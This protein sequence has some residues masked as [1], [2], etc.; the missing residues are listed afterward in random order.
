MEPTPKCPVHNQ[1]MEIEDVDRAYGQATW[2]CPQF[3]RGCR[4]VAYTGPS[5]ADI[6]R[7]EYAG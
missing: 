6:L 5:D 4:E 7:R 3:F 2:L 1:R